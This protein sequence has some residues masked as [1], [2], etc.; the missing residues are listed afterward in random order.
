[1]ETIWLSSQNHLELQVVEVEKRWQWIDTGTQF[2]SL[3][4]FDFP[5]N[6]KLKK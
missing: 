3:I 5:K 6:K 2:H 4:D 1:M